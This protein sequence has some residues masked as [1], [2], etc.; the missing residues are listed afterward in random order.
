MRGMTILFAIMTVTAAPG[1]TDSGQTPVSTKAVFTPLA[2]DQTPPE[3][4]PADA[5]FLFEIKCSICHAL[6]RPA[7]KKMDYN[8][9]RETVYRMKE[10]GAS[11]DEAEAEII[12]AYLAGRYGT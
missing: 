2:G 12:A 9:W 1:C 8:G 4:N 10:N 3:I 5:K 11:I 7:S 6:D